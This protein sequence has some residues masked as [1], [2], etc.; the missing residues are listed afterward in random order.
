MPKYQLPDGKFIDVDE[1][2][3]GSE[4][5][6]N[7]L[8][9]FNQRQRTRPQ[10]PI[11]SSP[12]QVPEGKE[13]NFL[14]D[15]F[16]VAPLEGGRKFLNSSGRLIEDI[17]DTIGRNTGIELTGDPNR[18]EF[19]GIKGFFY[20]PSQPD[21][22]DHTTG[23]VGK[24]VE[25]GT[26]F[27]LGF[28]VAGKILKGVARGITPVT[29][30][31]KVA[32]A[33][34]QGF[35]GDLIAFDENS[36][37]FAD[38]ITEFAPEFGD[39]YFKYLQTNKSDT[40][41]EGRLKN[42]LEGLGLGLLA[43]ALFIGAK[44]AKRKISGEVSDALKKDE[45]IIEKSQQAIIDAKP[46]LEEAKTIGEKM[47]IVNE[48][49]E[50][51]DGLTPIPKKIK[52]EDK[53]AFL[54]K[55]AKEDLEINYQKWKSGELTAE[56]A[57]AIPRAWIN[58]DTINKE[59]VS[60]DFV[61]NQLN[62]IELVKSTY[63]QVDKKFSDE[64]LREKGI[65]D[66]G[67]DFPKMYRDFSTITRTFK[68]IDVAPLIVQHDL[69]L[70][71]LIDNIPLLARKVKLGTATQKELDDHLAIIG[72]MQ[73]QSKFMSS[74]IGGALRAKGINKE[75]FL[76]SNVTENNLRNALTEYENFG[77]SD[78]KAKEALLNKL[79]VLDNPTITRKILDFAFTNR[80]WN[81]ANEV[82][83]NALLSN[84]KTQLINAVS[85]AITAIA[86][87]IEDYMGSKLSAW[88]DGDNL[89]KKAVYESQIKES[90]STLIGLF[91]YLREATKF[92][93]LALKNGET[94][95]DNIVKTDTALTKQVPTKFGGEIVRLP[96][97]ILNATDEAFKQINY[98]AKLSALAV[99]K[100]D[101]KGLKGKQYEKFV[102]EYIKQGFDEKGLRGTNAEALAYA[103]EATYTNELTGIA[104]KFQDAINTYPFL[105]QFFPF[106]RTPYQLAKAIAD[107][108]F[109]AVT[110]NIDHLLGQSGDP[111][112]I[113]KV[114][115]QFAMG[116]A[117]ISSATALY[118]LGLISGSTN[119]KDDGRAL[120]KYSDAELL[121]LKKSETN[122]KPYSF[123]I[124]DTQIQ[125]G[126][127]DPYGAFF[128][129]VADFMTHKEK[130]TREEIERIGADWHLFLQGQMDENPMKMST[131][132][133]INAISGLYSL[134]TNLL[135][136]TY[137]QGINDIVD[138]IYDQ[139]PNKFS[140]YLTNKLGS[141][142]PNIITKINNDPYLRDAQGIIEEVISKRAGIGVPPS[143]RYNFL[144]EAHTQGTEDSLQR[145]FNN[146]INPTAIG[147]QAD[148]PLAK[149]ILRIGKAPAVLQKFQNNVD[150]TQ[151]KFGNNT[152]Y[153]RLNQL[154]NSVKIEGLTLRQKLT[155]E[156]G[157]D[158]YLSKKDPVKLS[159]G[160]ETE[161]DKSTRLQ[162]L[163]EQYKTKAQTE[164]LKE[165]D[166][167]KHIDNPKRNLTGD[168]NKN[169]N[170]RDVLKQ[171]PIPFN[172]LQ[173]IINFFEQP[174]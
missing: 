32:Y 76:S 55:L 65:R 30:A 145:F 139:D 166:N 97:R 67:G 58:F 98:R 111:Q 84:P 20:D 46:R 119:Y 25:A 157:E 40:W 126:R 122:F 142:V 104:K 12:Q 51:V 146:F 71:S 135:A 133:G 72:A 129:L 83:I 26:Q 112:M 150:Y 96:T 109:G 35:I 2:F 172:K 107:R 170:N 163:Y 99:S 27:L 47:K 52:Q 94:V 21:K 143:P 10:V 100:A 164:F 29:T 61:K 153:D 115:G 18:R 117:L 156:I 70:R 43:E 73:N 173:P 167:Y 86:R 91:S 101:A 168:I 23:M 128:G 90:K 174:K 8:D 93:G 121:R 69:Y 63:K 95:L 106:V 144:G 15:T 158:T 31:E 105:K 44:V 5:E 53:V 149:E 136:K 36:G 9:D 59:L 56:E 42:G 60:Q 123:K 33:S 57:F 147:N 151:Y 132:L 62:I 4:D 171:N 64:V 50:T 78:P 110:Y 6:K 118:Q 159:R 39:T 54:S 169:I 141:F 148:E 66:Y 28:G 49:L 16:V 88:L 154:L 165:R 82:W 125:F 81:V 41:Y 77:K 34:T 155:K 140:K 3:I 87:P 22:D 13:N 68:D 116:T 17:G 45:I 74:E 152:A 124:G 80:V 79:V 113:A 7:F 1:S 130:F 131:R 92:T 138:A 103:Q 114:R 161:D 19:T 37:R 38:V 134:Q 162:F 24:F 85:N 160:I 137:I 102:D 11:Q 120:D 127:L 48:A 75:T 108:S 14:Y 89:A